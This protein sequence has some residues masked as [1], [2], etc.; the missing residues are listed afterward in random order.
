[1][2]HRWSDPDRTDPRCTLRVC[3]NPG[4]GMRKL[5]HHGNRRSW[6]TYAAGDGVAYHGDGTPTCFGTKRMAKALSYVSVCRKC[7]FR[8]Q[9][10]TEAV[11]SGETPSCTRCGFSVDVYATRKPAAVPSPIKTAAPDLRAVG[12]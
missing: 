6:R 3:L 10:T 4:C 8:L 7:S 11:Q 9:L 1:M 5:T 12:K 2:K